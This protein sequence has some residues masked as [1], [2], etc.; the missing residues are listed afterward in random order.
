[1][2]HVLQKNLWVFNPAEWLV[3]FVVAVFFFLTLGASFTERVGSEKAFIISSAYWLVWLGWIYYVAVR[4]PPPFGWLGL[5]RGMGPWIGLVFCYGQTRTLIPVIHPQMYDFKLQQ[6]DLGLMGRGTS[7]WLYA[8]DGHP[9]LTDFFCLIYLGLFGWLIGLIVYHSYLRRA[10]YQRF[11]MGLI[12]V[13]MGG[14]LGYLIYPAIGPRF[15]YPEQWTWLKGG[16][17]FQFTNQVVEKGGAQFDVFPSLHGAISAYLLFWQIGYDRRGLLWGL[18]LA[19]GIWISTL[20]LGYHYFPDLISGVLLAGAAAWLGPRLEKLGG[21]FRRTL[22]P[23][24][25]WLLNL[26]EGYGK[27]YGKLAG[28]LSDLIP[29]GAETSPGFICGGV[30]RSRGEEAVRQALGDL[31]KGPYWLRPS[32]PAG[33]QKTT[34]QSLKPLSEEQVLRTVFSSQAKRFFIAQKALK[35]TAVGL[36]RSFPPKGLQL[37]D[38]EMRVTSLPS[39]DELFLRLTPNR[40]LFKGWI[41]TPWNYFP[42]SFPLKGFELFEVV[43]LTRRLAQQWGGFSEVEWILSAGKV[44]VLD[45]RLVRVKITE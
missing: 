13:Y 12:L 6:L 21:A 32:D 41:D 29:L 30:P 43:Q 37:T 36:C 16:A 2:R 8:L 10:L 18:P 39:G 44:Y 15:A 22:D 3:T 40:T 45:G 11:M 34:L 5:L 25:V 4:R 28:R 9:F 1:L 17:I 7:K 26:T 27:V 24:R 42:K 23:P 14:F 31:G 38:V 33:S 19:A 35:V 20:L